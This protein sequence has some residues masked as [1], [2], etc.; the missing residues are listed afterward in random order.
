M[1]RPRLSFGWDELGREDEAGLWRAVQRRS[2]PSCVSPF[3]TDSLELMRRGSL[4]ATTNG[5]TRQW[6]LTW[7]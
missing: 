7:S 2:W 4:E 5:S 1:R 3:Y 6:T